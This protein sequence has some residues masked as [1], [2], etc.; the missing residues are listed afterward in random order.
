[1]FNNTDMSK[2]QA[3]LLC[4]D[5]VRLKSG[6]PAMTISKSEKDA[7]F[8]TWFNNKKVEQTWLSIHVLEP[9]LPGSEQ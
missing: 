5:V 9:V 2:P 8:C 4:G 7:R 6:G 1:M 3:H